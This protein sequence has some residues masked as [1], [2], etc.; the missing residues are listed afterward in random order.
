M[1]RIP[2]R[3]KRPPRPPRARAAAALPAALLALAP[4]PGRGQ[5]APGAPPAGAAPAQPP[6]RRPPRSPKANL[7]PLREG[8]AALGRGWYVWALRACG[9]AAKAD[10][11]ETYH[12]AAL[13]CQARA[14]LG[15]KWPQHAAHLAQQ[16]LARRDVST[17]RLLLGDALRLQGDCR[18]A[19][20][21]YLIV[22]E[23]DPTQQQ[24]IFGLRACTAEWP[25][26]PPPDGG[27]LLS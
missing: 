14:A 1:R 5:P 12:V 18:G 21:Q 19:R 6:E 26:P 16:A 17:A 22:L 23:R 9:R 3:L 2:A 7:D 4:A 10:G 24:A 8:E 13:L 27:P 11:G 20:T 15:L 25:P